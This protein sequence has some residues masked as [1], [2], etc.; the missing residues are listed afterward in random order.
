VL[1]VLHTPNWDK[2]Y[3]GSLSQYSRR[4]LREESNP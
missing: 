3:V 4:D 1:R 2:R